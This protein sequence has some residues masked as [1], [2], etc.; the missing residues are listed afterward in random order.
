MLAAGRRLAGAHVL[1]K[2]YLPCQERKFNAAEDKAH[3]TLRA[4]SLN[5]QLKAAVNKVPRQ[6][7]NYNNNNN[8][9][10]NYNH[11]RRFLRKETNKDNINKQEKEKEEG[12]EEKEKNTGK[13]ET[14]KETNKEETG[15][16]TLIEGQDGAAMV[17]LCEYE[18]AVQVPSTCTREA[19]VTKQEPC[20][21]KETVEEC[22]EVERQ[23]DR[24]C[25]RTSS[26]EVEVDCIDEEGGEGGEGGAGYT[27]ETVCKD[28]PKIVT[29]KGIK[30]N[31]I[32]NTFPCTSTYAKEICVETQQLVQDTCTV[33]LKETQEN[34]C[35][36]PYKKQSC[37][38]KEVFSTEICTEIKEEQVEYPC[39]QIVFQEKCTTVPYYE[40]EPCEVVLEET[41]LEACEGDFRITECTPQDT[42]Q[43]GTCYKDEEI[44]IN[45]ICYKIQQDNICEG[46]V[47]TR[48]VQDVLAKKAKQSK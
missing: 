47:T 24:T 41:I 30:F 5:E 26:K 32:V 21:Q 28:I 44:N 25:E 35:L 23:E 22:G 7:N 36:I 31:T 8:N 11:S 4:C 2:P 45:T 16:E 17:K 48:V 46:V 38:D 13:K 9:N 27:E 14:K 19:S 29:K 18:T 37:V 33:S 39:K 20:M 6:R 15:K 43:L 12:K 1:E 10:Y 42:P 34:S 40:L 3:G